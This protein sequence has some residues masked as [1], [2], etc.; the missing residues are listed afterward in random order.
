[1]GITDNFFEL[2]RYNLVAGRIANRI[3]KELD[4]EVSLNHVFQYQTIERLAKGVKEM[5]KK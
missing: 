3:F 2:G 5:K 1:M 4:K